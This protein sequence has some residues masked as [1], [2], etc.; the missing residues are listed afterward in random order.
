M[1][2]DTRF[3]KAL[4]YEGPRMAAHVCGWLVV[5][6][7]VF[8]VCEATTGQRGAGRRTHSRNYSTPL[9]AWWAR[10]RA[11]QGQGTWRAGGVADKGQG[12]CRG[13]ARG[14]RGGRG[15]VVDQGGHTA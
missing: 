4:G 7:W 9:H 14:G 12:M 8:G 11:V 3:S 2:K 1:T 13:R 10:A 5:Q 6:A 15:G